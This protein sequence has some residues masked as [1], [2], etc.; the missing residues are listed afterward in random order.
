MTKTWE[1]ENHKLIGIIQ[2]KLNQLNQQR[3]NGTISEKECK[4]LKPTCKFEGKL[5]K[6]VSYCY[7][8]GN[9][10]YLKFKLQEI[11]KNSLFTIYAYHLKPEEI[12]IK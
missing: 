3:V 10:H 1:K 8:V 11:G 9:H 4:D 7:S 2:S 6:I 12:Y 5:H